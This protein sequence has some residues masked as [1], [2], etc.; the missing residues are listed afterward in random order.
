MTNQINSYNCN[1]NEPNSFLFDLERYNNLGAESVT[2][3]AE[4]YL[5][6][7]YLELDIIPK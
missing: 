1:L 4:K 3:V 5:T 7:N 6:K 2:Q